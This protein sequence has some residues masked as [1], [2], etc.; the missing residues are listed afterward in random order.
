M[1]RKVSKKSKGH[2]AYKDG[3]EYFKTPS[4]DVYRA[5]RSNPLEIDTGYRSGARFESTAAAWQ[6]F[7]A[8]ILKGD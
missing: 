7:G 1:P 5:P 6:Y 8:R 2:I 3:Y 4:G